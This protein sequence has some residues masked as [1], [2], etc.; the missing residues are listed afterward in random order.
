MTTSHRTEWISNFEV[1]ASFVDRRR[2]GVQTL[3]TSNRKKKQKYVTTVFCFFYYHSISHYESKILI[4]FDNVAT[5]NRII[6][7]V[8]VY[9]IERWYTL[10]KRNI[11][12]YIQ[13]I[14]NMIYDIFSRLI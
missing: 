3:Q 5:D 1:G 4:R 7:V 2:T 11:V 14:N 6:N 9:A 10:C 8:L 13:S 12:K